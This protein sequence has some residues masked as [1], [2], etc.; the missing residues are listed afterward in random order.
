MA[1]TCW[2]WA[3]LQITCSNLHL[4]S[5]SIDFQ[6]LSEININKIL[7]NLFI[8]HANSILWSNQSM[9]HS[10]LSNSFDLTSFCA[11]DV[12]ALSVVRATFCWSWSR[13]DS[14]SDRNKLDSCIFQ[15]CLLEI[16][17]KKYFFVL[18]PEE[19]QSTANSLNRD[20]LPNMFRFNLKYKYYLQ[21][22]NSSV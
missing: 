10:R 18:V 13:F 8:F 19:S 2:L 11:A 12:E 15:W 7:L 6:Y 4:W 16:Q 17:N 22:I 14:E 5:W 20:N 21:W 9:F 3:H 1:A